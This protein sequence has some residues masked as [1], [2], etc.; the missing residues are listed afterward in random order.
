MKITSKLIECYYL[1]DGM[2][3]ADIS[4]DVGDNSGRVSVASSFCS[5]ENYWGA[6]GE[7]LKKFIQDIDIHYAA[8]KFGQSNWF[9]LDSTL[10]E[11]EQITK[12]E[13]LWASSDLIE[14]WNEELDSL[15]NSSCREEFVQ[16]ISS[17]CPNLMKLLDYQPSINT[18]IDPAFLSFWNIFWIPFIEFLKDE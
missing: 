12:E 6:C 8:K 16:L 18:S 15:K 13:S 2:E 1:R 7:P 9:D 14:S 4:L 17:E 10:S 5:F 11:I 3:Y